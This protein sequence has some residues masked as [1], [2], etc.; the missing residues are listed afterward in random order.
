MPVESSKGEAGRGQHEI[1]LDYRPAAE[2]AD[3]NLVFKNAVKEIAHRTGGR[4]RSWP[5]RDFDDAGSSC[6]IHSSLW[7]PDGHRPAFDDHHA[8]HDR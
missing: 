5:S 2:M 3:I 1:N 7:S 4:R 8:E 6:H